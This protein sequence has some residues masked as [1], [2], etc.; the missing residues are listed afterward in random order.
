MVRVVRLGLVALALIVAL[1]FF[2]L[3][4]PNTNSPVTAEKPAESFNIE[5]DAPPKISIQPEK[6]KSLCKNI[7][8]ITADVGVPGTIEG[9][10]CYSADYDLEVVFRASGSEKTILSSLRAWISRPTHRLHYVKSANWYVIADETLKEKISKEGVFKDKFVDLAEF[11]GPNRDITSE[12][13]CALSIGVMAENFLLDSL[14]LPDILAPHHR[15]VLS[16]NLANKQLVNEFLSLKQSSPKYRIAL[17]KILRE[18]N[19]LCAS[20]PEYFN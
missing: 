4:P 8:P 17:G 13:E 7:E 10:D 3:K 2:L 9:F 16:K 15:E 1:A 20:S 6:I 11:D 14:A 19:I 18:S 12:E 5:P